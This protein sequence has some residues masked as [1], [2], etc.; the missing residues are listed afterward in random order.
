M[1]RETEPDHVVVVGAGIVGCVVA[2]DLATDYEVTVLERDNVAGGA[3]GRSAGLIAP[4]LFYGD[5]PG[6]ARYANEFV[7]E[8]DGTGEFAF[9]ERDRLDF[10]TAEEEADADREATELDDAGFPVTY[11]ERSTVRERYPAFD[12][13]GFAGAVHYADTG[14]VDP[15]AY[16]NAMLQAA[17]DRGATVETGVSVARVT[18]TGGT[19]SGVETD[20]GR[21]EADAVVIAAGW[22]TADLV[23]EGLRLPIRPYRTQCVVLRPEDPLGE[24]FPLGRLGSEHLYFRPE[25][26]GDLLVGGAHHTVDDPQ[27]ATR[28][29]DETFKQEVAEVIPS[30]IGGFD[31][32]TYVNGWSGVDVAT[33]DTRPIV[34]A[35]AAGP[36]G[37]VIA[38]G[39][40]G[41]GV[42]M[43]P[44]AGPVARKRL[45]DDS[46]E[47]R[48]DPFALDR[49]DDVGDEFAYV[50]T[51]DL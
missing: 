25:H 29:A 19:V 3:T 1:N 41:L 18:A 22:R 34:D 37:L 15:H 20:A 35:P 4:S 43:A 17:R 32:S 39:F 28:G 16:A 14:W 50:S 11:L 40:N 48:T 13:D 5:L 49:F 24:E 36:D 12:L 42:M 10:V 8:L 7:R 31:R 6:V 27:N 33:P 46:P 44:I 21:Y 45:T 38:T 9:E 23:P 30:F 51:S 47:F 26:N 2:R